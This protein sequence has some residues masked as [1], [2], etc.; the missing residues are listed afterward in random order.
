[1]HPDDPTNA[2]VRNPIWQRFSITTRC[3]S[4]EPDSQ[5]SASYEQHLNN[6]PQQAYS[7]AKKRP[8]DF[9]LSP[10]NTSALPSCCRKQAG[11]A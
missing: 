5:I 1:M 2:S 6:P 8:D 4:P 9:A 3:S 7:V 11:N 10:R